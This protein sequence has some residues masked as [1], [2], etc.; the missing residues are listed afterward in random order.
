MAKKKISVTVDEDLLEFAADT[1]T[2]MS[3]LVNAALSE[4]LDRLAR[5][6]ALGELLSSWD[7]AMGPIDDTER[8]DVRA[9]FAD[10]DGELEHRATA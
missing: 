7:A 4:H 5:H 6:A 3:S 9:A 1:G 8:D 10:A 2:P